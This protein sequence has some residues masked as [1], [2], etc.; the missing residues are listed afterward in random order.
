MT[1]TIQ[2]ILNGQRTEVSGLPAT[3]T[4]LQY[5]RQHAALTG[6]KEGC[7]EGDCGACTVVVGTLD[8]TAERVDFAAI[9]A[10]IAFL[11]TLDG[12]QVITVEHLG[13]P[14]QM[15]PAQQAMLD[16]HGSQC[17][18]CTPGFVVSIASMLH[19]HDDADDDTIQDAIAG[20]LCRCT[21]YR[22]IVDAARLANKSK[23]RKLGADVA[24]LR[25]LR[26]DRGLRYV[27]GDSMFFSPVSAIELA[28]TLSA[29]PKATLLAGGTDVGLWVTKMH[30]ELPVVIYT[31]NVR[32]LHTL[33]TNGAGELTIGAAVSYTTAFE[34]LAAY[35]PSM[36]DLLKRLG[37]KQV[38]NAG[39]L[40][41]NI[42]N[43]SPIGDGM[44]PLIALG[45]RITL[46]SS[47]GVREVPLESY[48]LAYQKQDRQPDEFVETIIVPP[49]DPEVHF[50]TYKISKR[51]DQDISAVCFAFAYRQD[52]QSMR[53]VRLA[54]GGMAAT[55]KRA[56]N[57]EAVL[58]GQPFDEATLRKAQAALDRDF[59]PLTD[60]RASKEYRQQIAKNLLE[61]AFLETQR[62]HIETV[63][64]RYG[65]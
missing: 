45:A 6:T 20:N 31:G 30:R 61:R 52:G 62:P 10:C 22:P 13:T 49:R 16:C 3:T 11:P 19:Q 36:E 7:A 27:A 46:R 21:G 47:R 34:A 14:A 25:A 58:N 32:E 23:A 8:A 37:S 63:V 53:D 24:G 64:Y 54:Y 26:R 9:N 51:F 55:P 42:A 29:H 18:F 4:L 44:P 56:T 39:T 28:E 1:D 59:A 60:M 33:E 15:H 40:G 5:L 57:A 65:V 2:F 50:K 38:R 12:R 17:G 35:D 48:F 41:G 43:G